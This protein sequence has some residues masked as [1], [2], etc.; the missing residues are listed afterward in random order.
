MKVQMRDEDKTKEE[1][2]RFLDHQVFAKPVKN[3]WF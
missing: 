3:K 1:L 2:D